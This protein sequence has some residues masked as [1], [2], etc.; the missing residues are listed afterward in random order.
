MEVL[1]QTGEE[2]ALLRDCMRKAKEVYFDTETNSLK[3]DRYATMF[4]FSDGENHFAVPVRHLKRLDDVKK[5][6]MDHL[7]T[8]GRGKYI[9]DIMKGWPGDDPEGFDEIAMFIVDN[10]EGDYRRSEFKFHPE[11]PV[12]MDIGPIVEITR[13]VFQNPDMEV[14]IHNAQFDIGVVRNEGISPDTFQCTVRDLMGLAWLIDPAQ[15]KSLK[16]LVAKLL[17][18]KMTEFKEFKRYGN[19]GAHMIPIGLIRQYAIDDVKYMQPLQRK[20][21]VKLAYMG[22]HMVKVWEELETPMVIVTE[23]MIANG[24]KV[25]TQ[26]LKDIAVDLKIEMVNIREKVAKLADLKFK[27]LGSFNSTKWMNECFIVEKKLWGVRKR[28]S[29]GTYGYS[30][31][32]GVLSDWRTGDPPGTKPAGREIATLIL[33]WR[34]ISKLHSTYASSIHKMVD[35]DSRVHSN[36]KQFGTRTGRYSSAAPNLQN[37]PRDDEAIPSIRAAFIARDNGYSIIGVDYSQIELRVIAHFSEDPVMTDIY[38]N[39]GDIHQTTA[40]AVGCSRQGAKGLNFG[41]QYGMGPEK[42]AG[43]IGCTVQ[44][45]EVFIAK[46]FQKY[47]YIRYFQERT[48]SEAR[49]LGYTTT[50]VGRRRYLPELQSKNWYKRGHAERSSVNTRVQGSAADLIKISMR[51]LWT[52][53]KH[54]WHHGAPWLNDSVFMLSQVH[55]ELLFEARAE[56]A[57]D[58]A[59]VI[60]EE[61]ESAVKLKVPLL[62]EPVIASN[63]G[64][65]K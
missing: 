62:A 4:Q 39:N 13:E 37:I 24:F 52:R 15:R 20:L 19:G 14:W 48:K 22:D 51:N 61:M 36:F 64:D 34:K 16:K 9:Y 3:H 53:F 18:Y 12:N 2:M 49:N 55:D 17:D 60:Q 8:R 65:A 30:C 42:M 56:L 59:Q 57:E 32:K 28:W 6:M 25:D 11:N 21:V 10:S 46:Y 23:S 63:W 35:S 33:R 38:R 54:E 31:A 43:T 40:D 27:D 5:M 50:L 7:T 45:A 29:K 41:L 1:V 44:E 26:Y 58:I 47:E